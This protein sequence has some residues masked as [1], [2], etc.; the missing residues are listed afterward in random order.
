VSPDGLLF[1]LLLITLPLTAAGLNLM[2]LRQ[3]GVAKRYA[4]ESGLAVILLAILMS[5]TLEVPPEGRTAL[6]AVTFFAYLWPLYAW[7][8]VVRA[9]QLRWCDSALALVV[10]ALVAIPIVGASHY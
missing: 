2:R 6:R 5:V 10:F 7:V 9:T 8:R 3:N 4:V 1:S